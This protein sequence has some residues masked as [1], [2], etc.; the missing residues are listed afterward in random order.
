VLNAMNDRCTRL[1]WTTSP[2]WLGIDD[3]IRHYALHPKN[4]FK[5]HWRGLR[6]DDVERIVSKMEALCGEHMFNQT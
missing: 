3:Q 1:N 2:V 4:V 6:L 5:T